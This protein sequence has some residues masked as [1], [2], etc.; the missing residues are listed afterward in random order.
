MMRAARKLGAAITLLGSFVVELL[1]AYWAVLRIVVRPKLALRPGI[2]AYH[3]ELQTDLAKTWLANMI[4]LT[5]GT[6]TLFVSDDRQTLYI[7]TLDI[8]DPVAIADSIR[9][10]FETKLLELEK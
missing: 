1:S 6:L 4:T 9:R 3:T 10:A 2:L 7:H 8:D 5:P